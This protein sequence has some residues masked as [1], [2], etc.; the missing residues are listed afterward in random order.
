VFP[1]LLLSFL[2]AA[3]TMRAGGTGYFVVQGLFGT[4]SLLSV[5]NSAGFIG[6]ETFARTLDAICQVLP[7]FSFWLGGES[8][9]PGFTTGN[10]IGQSLALAVLVVLVA[11]QSRIYW[12]TV[13][14]FGRR[15]ET[16]PAGKP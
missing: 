14:R 8:L 11:R 16:P 9:R 3:S 4:I 5:S 7:V 13:A 12:G 6:G 15:A 2:P 10:V 1:A